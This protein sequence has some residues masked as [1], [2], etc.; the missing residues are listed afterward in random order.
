MGEAMAEQFMMLF[1]ILGS[2]LHIIVHIIAGISF[3][4]VIYFAYLLYKETDKGWYWISLFLSALSFASA[5]W[6]TII[7]P[8]GR[9]DFPISQ[10]LSDLAN[11]SGAILFAVSCYGLYK[12]MHYI[13]KRVE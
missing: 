7:F 9:R 4:G 3:L 12:T 6:F 2:V 10:T 1:W 13:R 11:I 5:E 8:M